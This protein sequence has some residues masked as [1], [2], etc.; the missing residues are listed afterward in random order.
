MCNVILV[1]KRWRHIATLSSTQGNVV[2]VPTYIM[3]VKIKC[4]WGSSKRR[5]IRSNILC[6]LLH[7]AKLKKIHVESTTVTKFANFSKFW[8][9]EGK[10]ENF[11]SGATWVLSRFVNLRK[12]KEVLG[13]RLHL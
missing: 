1:N 11:W 4:C 8:D 13:C 10:I 6:N 2:A 12:F 9:D 5:S 3:C 7:T